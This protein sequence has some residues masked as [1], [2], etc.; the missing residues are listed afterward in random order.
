M[1]N[2]LNARTP[3]ASPPLPMWRL[4]DVEAHTGLRKSTIY[5]GMRAGTFP[6]CVRLSARAVAWRASDVV[7]W[8]EARTSE[9][10]DQ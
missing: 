1:T 5:A 8:C 3:A 4:P 7:A 2:T 9:G 10:G 6:K